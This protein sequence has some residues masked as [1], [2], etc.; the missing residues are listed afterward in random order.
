VLG[1]EKHEFDAYEW[2]HTGAERGKKAVEEG[3]AG[4]RE[5][6]RRHVGMNKGDKENPPHG[7]TGWQTQLW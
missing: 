4:E 2:K 5:I 7:L 1:K 3:C 6:A